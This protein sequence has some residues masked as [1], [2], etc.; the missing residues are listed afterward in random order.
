MRLTP[1][2]P[3]RISI[4][5]ILQSDCQ[6]STWIAERSLANLNADGFWKPCRQF[7]R[8]ISCCHCIIA[9]ITKTCK[10]GGVFR[11]SQQNTPMLQDGSATAALRTSHDLVVL[12]TI[13]L[14]WDKDKIARRAALETEK[15]LYYFF[16]NWPEL[17]NFDSLGEANRPGGITLRQITTQDRRDHFM[18]NLVQ[19]LGIHGERVLARQGQTVGQLMIV[20]NRPAATLPADHDCIRTRGMPSSLRVFLKVTKRQRRFIPLIEPQGRKAVIG[21]LMQQ[22]LIDRH[23]PSTTLRRINNQLTRKM[24]L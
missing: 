13:P 9:E 22:R 7:T 5:I 19:T 8:Q 11:P 2:V 18:H 10:F 3:S 20:Q 1:L 17:T 14:F 16:D 23:V 12:R 21:C 6:R 15:R 4:L 24:S